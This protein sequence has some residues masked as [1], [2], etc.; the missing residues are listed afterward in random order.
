[1]IYIDTSALVPA[2]IREPKSEA[3]LA[4]IEVSGEGNETGHF[5]KQGS[6]D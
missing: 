5:A 1:M 4:W 2:F 6:F 3:V